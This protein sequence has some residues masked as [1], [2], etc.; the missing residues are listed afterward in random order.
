MDLKT[1]YLKYRPQNLSQLDLVAV[2]EGLIKVVKSNKILHAFLF[3]GPK[4]IGKT[5]AARVLAKAFN[6]QKRKKSGDPCN[7]CAI[8]RSITDGTA[9]DLIE[10]DAASNRG[11]DDIRDLRRKIK[12]APAR[13]QYKV[14][15]V[16]EAHMLTKEAF[17]ALLKTLEEPPAHAI[18]I[19]CT[20]EP[21]KLPDTIISRCLHFNFHKAKPDEVVGSLQKVV[22]GEKL[23][24]AKGVLEAIA[25]SADGSFRDA[26]KLL[27]QLSMSGPKISLTDAQELLEQTE[28]LNPQKLFQ[29]LVKADVRQ[30]LQEIGRVAEA[31]SDL[32]FY[33]QQLLD[34]L[35][36]SLLAR[37]GISEGAA[38]ETLQGLS[39]GQIKLLISLFSQSYKEIKFSPIPQLPLEM[40]VVEFCGQTEAPPAKS[41]ERPSIVEQPKPAPVTKTAAPKKNGE[42]AKLDAKWNDIL[43][44]VKPLNHSVQALLRASRPADFDGQKL[45]LEVFYKFHKERL[46]TA[47]CREIVEQVTSQI[48]AT[49]VRLSCVLGKKKEK[50]D[51]VELA[52]NIFK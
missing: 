27:E 45:T 6:C 18:F 51:I 40:A 42:F 34:R 41:K 46:E 8:C 13:C 5:S 10:I 14:Y 25:R 50:K 33:T 20:T 23:Q 7:R 35:R 24:V 49:P 15:I 29:A 19:L 3:T 43:E 39:L 44:Q 16:D 38:A 1:F 17:N 37:V 11:I 47:K 48:L 31:G 21:G 28:N 26:Q 32:A 30:A 4:G 2:R 22:K 12:L 36:V 9:L 52:E